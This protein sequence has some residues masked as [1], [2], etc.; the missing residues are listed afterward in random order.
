MKFIVNKYKVMH[1]A[2]EKLNCFHTLLGSKLTTSA[3][4][5]DLDV[6]TELP[7]VTPTK[8]AVAVRK[9]NR[10]QSRKSAEE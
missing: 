7:T 2:G 10:M 9:Q 5:G 3:Q 1:T 4:K 8:C 6:V